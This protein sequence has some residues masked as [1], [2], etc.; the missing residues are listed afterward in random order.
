MDSV[1]ICM[2]VLDCSPICTHKDQNSTSSR[3]VC[4]NS[5]QP[6]N[7]STQHCVRTKASECRIYRYRSQLSRDR[8]AGRLP[9]KIGGMRPRNVAATG[10]R[11]NGNMPPN[12]RR[13]DGTPRPNFP[14]MLAAGS[15]YRASHI[16]FHAGF[17]AS[18]NSRS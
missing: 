14:C 6:K 16:L 11:L 18:I 4:Q 7:A 10:D 13:L 12:N 5:I 2:R 1:L 17:P 15:V 8:V 3:D 9:D